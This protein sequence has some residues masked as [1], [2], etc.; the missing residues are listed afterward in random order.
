[1]CKNKSQASQNKLLW[2]KQFECVLK[3]IVSYFI[4]MKQIIRN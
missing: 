2:A 1:M 4:S 3:Y